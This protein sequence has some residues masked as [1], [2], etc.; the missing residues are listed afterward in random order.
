MFKKIP[1]T[2]TI[3]SSII[4]ICAAL[5]W[6]IPPGEYVRE[7]VEVNGSERTV[8]VEGSFHAAERSPQTWQVFT[9]LLEGFEKQ[10]GIIAFLLIIGGAF[11]VMNSSRAVD[12][13]IGAF[14][15]FTQGLERHGWIGAWGWIGWSSRW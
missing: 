2:Y 12:A 1:H 9:S 4:L 10:A 13:G 14:L 6:V 8:I 7:R 15:R 11:Q 5:S 3:I